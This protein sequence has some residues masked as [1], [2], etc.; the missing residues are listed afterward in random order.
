[1]SD[2]DKA[3]RWAL[4]AL[5]KR[6]Y[7]REELRQK[8][9]ARGFEDA[10]VDEALAILSEQRLL[11][12]SRA[13]EALIVSRSGKRAV[14]REALQEE[15]LQRGADETKLEL[16]ERT[17]EQ[18]LAIMLEVIAKFED[19]ARAGRLLARRGFDPDLIASV[20]ER[21]FGEED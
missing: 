10:I 9:A 6:E 4:R 1:M 15:L 13:T 12:D 7:F 14:G 5:G 20:L 19:R 2:R 21:H 3:L 8:L 18:E 17:D 11:S 16:A